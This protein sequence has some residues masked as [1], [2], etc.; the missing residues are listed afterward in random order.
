[1]S[2]PTLL[3]DREGAVT[4]LT[5]NRPQAMNAL[6]DGLVRGLAAELER[7]AGD[8]SVRAVVLQGAGGSFCSGADLKEALGQLGSG[9]SLADRLA[10]FQACIRA[11]ATAPKPVIAAVDGAAV[12][13]GAD[14]ALACD[15]R[16]MSDRAYLQEKFVGIGLMPDGGGTFHLSRLVGPGRALELLLLGDKVETARALELGLTNRVVAAADLSRDAIALA[17]RLAEGPPLALA[18]IKQATRAAMSGTLEE[19]LAREGSGQARLLASADL[20]EGIAAWTERRA[21]TFTGK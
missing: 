16:L 9:I 7:A 21:P 12:G 10:P 19:A 6:D 4:V 18:A 20:R 8:G 15:L 3:V 13:F 17:Q 2:A 5:L 14:L 1:M 11:I